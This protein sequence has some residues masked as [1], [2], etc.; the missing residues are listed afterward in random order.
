MA[1]GPATCRNSTPKKATEP[2]GLHSGFGFAM[3]PETTEGTAVAANE[4]YTNKAM[5]NHAKTYQGF[6]TLLKAGIIVSILALLILLI[7]YVS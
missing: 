3:K 4:E 1:A 5:K 7:V 6:L 2:G